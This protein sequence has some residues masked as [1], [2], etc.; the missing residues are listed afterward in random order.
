MLHVG[1]RLSACGQQ[2]GKVVKHVGVHTVHPEQPFVQVIFNQSNRQRQHEM[3]IT[4]EDLAANADSSNVLVG[5]WV[6]MHGS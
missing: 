5:V 1:W 2:L 4:V 3:A 6:H